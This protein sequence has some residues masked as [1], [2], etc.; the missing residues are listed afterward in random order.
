MNV[1]VIIGYLNSCK[2]TI[3]HLIPSFI[4]PLRNILYFWKKTLLSYLSFR[5]Y[6]STSGQCGK[7]LKVQYCTRICMFYLPKNVQRTIGSQGF[8]RCRLKWP[9]KT[10]I[11]EEVNCF[12]CLTSLNKRFC[13]IS[14]QHAPFPINQLIPG[15]EDKKLGN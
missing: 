6:Y 2:T 7:S 12:I 11:C 1:F 4:A 15:I 10:S 5:T 9:G 13:N 3:T 8:W 14:T